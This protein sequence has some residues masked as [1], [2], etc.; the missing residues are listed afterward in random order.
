MFIWKIFE[1]FRH[2]GELDPRFMTLKY[3]E[4]V[5]V[6][7]RHQFCRVRQSQLSDNEYKDFLHFKKKR[8]RIPNQWIL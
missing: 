1:S 2:L 5:E 8:L 3:I 4:N 6:P 7:Y